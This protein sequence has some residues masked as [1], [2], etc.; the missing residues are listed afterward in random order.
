MR[1]AGGTTGKVTKKSQSNIHKQS[2]K[3]HREQA[4]SQTASTSEHSFS[5]QFYLTFPGCAQARLYVLEREQ[6][7]VEA[8]YYSIFHGHFEKSIAFMVRA[9]L[10]HEVMSLVQTQSA[11]SWDTQYMPIC[12]EL[13]HNGKTE[14]AI[15]LSAF[16]AGN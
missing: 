13:L 3:L 16:C 8:Y 9:D 10:A 1:T 4:N 15:R 11:F 2:E 12:V 6:K 14:T 7:W 5:T